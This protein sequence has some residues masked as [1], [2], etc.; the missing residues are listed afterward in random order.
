MH[1]RV[2]SFTVV[3]EHNTEEMIDRIRAEVPGRLTGLL[4][5]QQSFHLGPRADNSALI[6]SFWDSEEDA[7]AAVPAIQAIWADF[8]HI[9]AAPPKMEVYEVAI[10]IQA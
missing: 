9:I 1:A 8:A 3:P 2:T 7:Y 10:H 6:V 5:F 4:G